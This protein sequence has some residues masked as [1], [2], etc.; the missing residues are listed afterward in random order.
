[1][2]AIELPPFVPFFLAALLAAVTR[3]WLR[4]TILLLAPVLGGLH[5]LTMPEEIGRAHV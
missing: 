2:W 3:G 5:L 4:S 1:M